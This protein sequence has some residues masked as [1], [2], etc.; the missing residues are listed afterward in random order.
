MTDA[1]W[2]EEQVGMRSAINERA[3]V[4]ACLTELLLIAEAH[5]GVTRGRE[6]TRERSTRDDGMTR[7]PSNEFVRPA[8]GDGMT[9]DLPTESD[10]GSGEFTRA[11]RATCCVH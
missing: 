9:R 11:G 2:P 1:N 3:W 8:R 10:E 6:I 4:R 5:Y 7:D